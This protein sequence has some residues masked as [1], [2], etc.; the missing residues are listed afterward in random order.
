MGGQHGKK[1]AK[2]VI[3]PMDATGSGLSSGHGLVS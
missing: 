2:I 1:L 3:K